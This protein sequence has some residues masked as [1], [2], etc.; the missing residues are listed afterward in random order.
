MT[1]AT[2]HVL[3]RFVFRHR[4]FRIKTEIKRAVVTI[5]AIAFEVVGTYYVFSQNMSFTEGGLWGI[6]HSS[7][8][9]RIRDGVVIYP[10]SVTTGE[11]VPISKGCIT[12]LGNAVVTSCAVGKWFSVTNAGFVFR[13]TFPGIIFASI[14]IPVEKVFL[15]AF[16]VFDEFAIVYAPFASCSGR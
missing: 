8:V 5:F 3:A 4:N 2:A 7:V 10:F 15:A 9:T 13:R 1:Q 6:N 11:S 16:R 14:V 12:A